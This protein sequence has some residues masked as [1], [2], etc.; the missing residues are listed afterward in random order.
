MSST[1]KG[2]SLIRQNFASDVE[3]RL[4]KQI[5]IELYASYV[6][7]S[8]SYYFDRDDVALENIAKWMKYTKQSDEEREHAQILMKYQNTRGGRLVLQ[9]VQKPEKDE[10]GTALEAFEAALALE[11]FNNQSLLELHEVAGQNNDCQMCGKKFF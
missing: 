5:N 8:M 6:Y 4:N 9:N 7:L 10:W 11:R 3:A 2:E 1:K